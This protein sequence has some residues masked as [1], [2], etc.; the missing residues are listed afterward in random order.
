MKIKFFII[1]YIIL[2]FSQ[3]VFG[4]SPATST[5]FFEAYLDI[6]LVQIAQNRAL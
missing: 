5:P 3:G 1:L 4:D 6:P 2:V